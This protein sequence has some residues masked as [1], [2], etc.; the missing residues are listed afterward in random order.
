MDKTQQVAQ[1]RLAADLLETGHPW[2]TSHTGDRWWTATPSD[3]P[4]IHVVNNQHIRPVLATP[5]DGRPLHNPDNLTA[6][7]VGI[8]WR[9]LTKDEFKQDLNVHHY[10]WWTINKQWILE[11]G[12]RTTRAPLHNFGT[13][14]RLPLSVP[15]PEKPDPY[16]ELKK[17]HAEGKV[18]QVYH[19]EG[20]HESQQF[21]KDCPNPDW[22]PH[23]DYRIKPDSLFQ[24]PPPPPNMRWHSQESWNEYDTPSGYRLLVEGETI[25]H[26]DEFYEKGWLK[27]NEDLI[28]GVGK[29][30]KPIATA[31]RTRRPL[32]FTHAGKQWTW[33]RPGDP[34]PCDGEKQVVLLRSNRE[35]FATNEYSALGKKWTWDDPLII[36]WRYAD[37]KKTAPLGPEMREFLDMIKGRCSKPA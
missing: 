22:M 2:E 10:E 25:Q 1:L 37:E 12:I 28:F 21:W 33:H 32:T 27:A 36:G 11:T 19:M 29:T 14:Y 5:P 3:N 35:E 20:L 9:L 4:A 34:M 23:Q 7:Q 18:I 31:F 24:A 26:G 17:A 6:E 15:W 13:T 16:A 30:I 8:G